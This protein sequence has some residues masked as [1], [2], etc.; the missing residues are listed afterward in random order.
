MGSTFVAAYRGLPSLKF[1]GD[2]LYTQ[3]RDHR[4]SLFGQRVSTYQPNYPVCTS[5]GCG[6]L[7]PETMAPATAE[8]SSQRPPQPMRFAPP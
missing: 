4:Y 8:I 2:R 3:I 7:I 6:G 1:L 5:N